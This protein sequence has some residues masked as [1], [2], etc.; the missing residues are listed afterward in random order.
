M[1]GPS[2]EEQRGLLAAIIES[3]GDAIYS[4]DLKGVIT[5]WNPAAERLF[6]CSSGEAVG[7]PI[8]FLIPAGRREEEREIH[9][10]VLRGERV[11]HYRTT[12]LHRDGH[13]VEISLSVSPVRG[14][15]GRIIG[16]SAIARDMSE[17]KR[18]EDLAAR[19]AEELRRSNAEL[20]RFAY[21]A[22]HDLQEPL[23]TVT[24]YVQLLARR[25]QGRLDPDADDFIAYAVDGANRMRQLIQDL[26]AYSRVNTTGSRF[27]RTS[28][29]KVLPAV[30][31]SLEASLK[32][33]GAVV[34]HGPLP[35]V[36]GDESQL[37]QLL[38]NLIANAI[39]FRGAG[40]PRIHLEA[41]R[42][43]GEWRVSVRD[44]GVGIDPRYFERI[45]VIFQRLHNRAEYGGTGI[46]LA[47]CK[48]IVEGHGGRIWVESGPEGGSAFFFTLPAEGG[49]A[50]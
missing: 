23:R 44:N 26:L 19:Q 10:R 31:A 36:A 45:F 14:D 8:S 42:L 9:A 43:A 35:E 25:Y 38:Q 17:Q 29:E 1:S 12:R 30:L 16:L 46:G 37:E 28:L 11:E 39:R 24:S 41:E 7:Q 15:G 6:G 4:R 32:E 22:S 48:K 21:V 33:A 13:P 5:T 47:L 49:N 27:G 2:P 20:E 50:I 34:T 3:S 40:P 18:Y